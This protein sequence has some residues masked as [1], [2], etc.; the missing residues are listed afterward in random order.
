M[1]STRPGNADKGVTRRGMAR[2]SASGFG[3][4]HPRVRESSVIAGFQEAAGAPILSLSPPH[5]MI[6]ALLDDNTHQVAELAQATE[7]EQAWNS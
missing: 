7:D 2:F 5:S 4:G 3:Q 6:S 1:G